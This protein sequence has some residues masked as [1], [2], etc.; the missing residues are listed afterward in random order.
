MPKNVGE[1]PVARKMKALLLD[2]LHVMAPTGVAAFNVGGFTLHSL[3]HLP[4]RGEFK[5]PEGEQLQQLQRSFSGVDYFVI[6]EMS[7]LG[8]KHD[9]IG[10]LTRGFAR[11][12][13]IVLVRLWDGALVCL[14]VALVSFLQS[15]TS[16]S[17]LLYPDQPL[18]ILA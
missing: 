11:L 2:R 17:T 1:E 5:A 3:L 15:W 7:M 8:R 4:T 13:H 6:D 12:F 18:L 14:W 9:Q 10:R 16:P